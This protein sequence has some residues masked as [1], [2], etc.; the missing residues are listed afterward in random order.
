MFEVSVDGTVV[1]SKKQLGRHA[2]PGEVVDLIRAI[3]G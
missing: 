3:R 1:F 2:N